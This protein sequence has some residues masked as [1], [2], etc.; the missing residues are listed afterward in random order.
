MVFLDGVGLGAADPAGN[1]LVAEALPAFA[2]LAGG[3]PWTE[4]LVPV[5]RP[6]HV[7][8]GIDANL[9]LPG[10]PQSGTGQATLFTGINCAEVAGRH[11]GPFPHSTSKPVI[12]AHNIF[13]HLK[14]AGRPVAFAN[15]YPERF[16][17][18]VQ[19]R[20]RWTVTTLCCR[21]AGVPLR[22]T[23][24]LKAGRALSSD[25]TAA[26]WPEQD[27]A[28]QPIT[29]AEAA[30]RLV[31]LAD[32]HTFTLFEYYWTD[33]A[34]HRQDPAEAARVLGALDR[35]FAG[36]LEAIDPTRHLLLITS[37]HGNLEDLTTKSHTRNPVPLIAY[38]KNAA[39]FAEV[40]DLTGVVP[41]LRQAAG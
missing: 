30:R 1:P 5:A 39:S 16:F 18:W 25:L 23:A 17:A 20:N 7:V 15:A 29:E 3:Q 4:A 27:D 19:Q 8:R 11:F 13:V 14:N 6:G 40:T 21:A 10:L 33:K 24:D 32:A 2:E 34:G 36:L 28:W 9:G 22:R 38:G 37:D 41:A 26:R 35:F 12:A 31:R